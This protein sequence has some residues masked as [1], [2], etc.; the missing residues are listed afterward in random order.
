[1]FNIKWNDGKTSEDKF[2][3][4]IMF[5]DGGKNYLKGDYSRISNHYTILWEEDNVVGM[6]IYNP[7]WKVVAAKFRSAMAR[8][9]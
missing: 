8:A 5:S 7:Q 1:M 4:E 9:S 3:L 6:T 2:V